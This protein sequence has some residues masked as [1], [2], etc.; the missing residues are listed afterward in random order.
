MSA[1]TGYGTLLKMGDGG[2]PEAFATVAGVRDVRLP[3]IA[4][5]LIDVT[6]QENNGWRE[7]LATL[8]DPGEVT[9]SIVF[10]LEEATHG[11][12]NGLLKRAKD[13][14]KVNWKIEF[15]QYTPVKTWSFSG[16]ITNFTPQ[17]RI[18][19]ELS[20]DV[21]IAVTGQPTFA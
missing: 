5:E 7:K 10:D 17:A 16:Y 9:F 12:T 4:L 3:G 1:K 2:T 8:K 21:T 13:G 19:S 15:T 20:A 14:A 18:G 6:T 11:A